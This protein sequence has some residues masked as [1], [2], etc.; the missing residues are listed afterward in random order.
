MFITLKPTRFFL[1]TRLTFLLNKKFPHAITLSTN[2]NLL[3]FAECDKVFHYETHVFTKCQSVSGWIYVYSTIVVCIEFKFSKAPLRVCLDVCVR[4][5]NISLSK[6]QIGN[7]K[8]VS[9]V[10]MELSLRNSFNL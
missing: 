1:W 4:S 5:D 2:G 3:M 8:E 9:I 6:F 10:L 7:G